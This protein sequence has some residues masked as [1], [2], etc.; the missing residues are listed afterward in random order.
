LPAA[1]QS[2]AAAPQ[3]TEILIEQ[4]G[5][6]IRDPAITSLLE[7]AVGAPFA[8]RDVR[9]TITHLVS[10]NRF[11]DVRVF[12]EDARGGVR[13]RYV[14]YPSHPVDRL[15]FRG[16][17]G[18]SQDDL[19]RVVRERFGTSPPQAPRADAVAMVLREAY[20]S[21]GYPQARVT[22]RIEELHDPDRATLVFNVEAGARVAI[23]HVT[24]EQADATPLDTVVGAPDVRVGQPYD[25]ERID[26]EL[27][28]YV[29]AMHDREYLEARASHEVRFTDDGAEVT[30]KVTRGPRVAIAWTGDSIP[31]KERNRLVPVRS[32][33]SVSQDLLEDA[34]N[35][36]TDYLRVRGY[37]DAR[38]EF[39]PMEQAGLLTITFSV[40]RGP[41]YV[42]DS[43]VVTGNTALTTVEVTDTVRLKKGEPFIQGVVDGAAGT[44]RNLYRNRGY[45]K[46]DVK[47]V[48]TVLPQDRPEDVERRVAI[49]M[50]IVEGPR[51]VVRAIAVQGNMAISEAEVRRTMTSAV[52]RAYSEGD[53]IGDRDRIELEYR[54]RG[55][56]TVVVD[57]KVTFAENDTR[58][59]VSFTI[60]EGPQVIVDHVIITGN[61]RTSTGTIEREVTLRPGQPMGSAALIESQQRLSALGLF[62][63]VRLTELQR[64]GEARR[65]LLVHV[66]EAPP[67][68][69]AWGGG[70]EVGSRLRTNEEG[71]AVERYDFVPRG[72]FE[73]GRRNMWGKN[74][75]VDLFTRLALRSR[76]LV[77]TPG[78]ITLQEQTG[79]LG[80]NEYRVFATYR[81]PRILN[82]RADLLLTGILDQAIRSSFNFNRRE[83]RAEVGTRLSSVYSTSARYSFE[84]TRLFDEHFTE[85]EKPLIDRLF[86]QVRLSKLSGTLIRDSRR[87]QLDPDGGTLMT[88]TGDLALRGIGSEVGFAK[89]FVEAFAYPRLPLPRRTI[90]A[91]GARLG[92]AHGFRRDVEGTSVQDIPVSER[93]FAGGDTSVRGFSLDRLGTRNTDPAGN[94]ENDTITAAGFPTG[95]NAVV[96]FNTELRITVTKAVEA[97]TFVDAGNVYAKTSALDLTNL[98]PAAGFGVRLRL[99][100]V[101]MIRVDLGFNLDR[102]ELVPGRLERGMVF[103]VSLGQAF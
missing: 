95:G 41:R 29:N 56:E 70:L 13:L 59:D 99:P 81:E 18:V 76:D 44:I 43:I 21:R 20:R 86:P 27:T 11:D 69:I 84:R 85:E 64:P 47:P 23:T 19:R 40:Q 49:T 88:V 91:M 77:F 12:R 96:I 25:A 53:V 97:V 15:E 50:P 31:E 66:E 5:R 93:F 22:P 63:L 52:G 3:V 30:L 37:R 2:T 9:E 79:G 71:T 94:H 17:L 65:D 33:A 101:P 98:R 100:V 28:K 32:E 90:L 16:T 14:L 68:T 83:A 67:T 89:T 10:L 55:Y 103:H 39:T 92:A 75:S 35:A 45:T 6:V 34:Q 74:R 61:T 1:A 8:V 78:G 46:A 24:V 26:R 58:A 36:V 82:S 80:F 102:R 54:N 4:E 62:R 48:V 72:S 87:D 51:T 57:P 38:V 60:A 73:I 42:V 7:T